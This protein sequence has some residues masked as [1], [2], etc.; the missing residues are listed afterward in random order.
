MIEHECDKLGL[1]VTDGE[2]QE[3]LRQGDAQSLQ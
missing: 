3:A 1:F 2:V